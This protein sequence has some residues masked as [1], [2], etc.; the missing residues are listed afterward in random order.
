[1]RA[2]SSEFDSIAP[3]DSFLGVLDQFAALRSYR[4]TSGVGGYRVL[5]PRGRGNRAASRYAPTAAALAAIARGRVRITGSLAVLFIGG[6]GLAVLAGPA[7]CPCTAELNVA[8]RSSLTRLGYIENAHFVSPR[9]NIARPSE[10]PA[11]LPAATVAALVEPTENVAGVSP[12][13]TSAL[14][15]SALEPST[16][17]PSA[18][19]RE[20]EIAS[21]ARDGVGTVGAGALPVLIEP[22]SD[23]GPPVRLAAASN[24][25]SD[26]TPELP[27]ITAI[28]P[29]TKAVVADA[30]E[31]APRAKRKKNL[32]A[33]RTPIGKAERHG[34]Q[35]GNEQL[36]KR[37]PKWAQQ[38]Y[39]TPW[40][41]QAFS[42]TR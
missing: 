34:S 38:M 31:D 2:M 24:I 7:N 37:A 5:A 8:Q 28:T 17:G 41:M 9:E 26:V 27:V 4:D 13:T 25:E 39:V 15:P 10:S 18:V 22:L 40:Q 23:A 12:I 42:Y 14:E 16:L 36:V 21:V 29:P 6:L 1:M 33:Y 20:H 35:P 32:R 11:E 19:K 3:A 30:D